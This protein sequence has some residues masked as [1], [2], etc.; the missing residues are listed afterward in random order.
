MKRV[1]RKW[2][3]GYKQTEKLQSSL[4]IRAVSLEAFLF[5]LSYIKVYCLGKQ[6]AKL[7]AS[8][9]GSFAVCICPKAHFLTTR[10]F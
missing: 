6:T 4:R 10:L 7:L 3:L 5:A 1:V 9:R 2:A 8:L